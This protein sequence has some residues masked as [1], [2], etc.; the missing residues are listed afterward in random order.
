[1]ILGRQ[2]IYYDA[3][4]G[5]WRDKRL[6]KW[7][8][9]PVTNVMLTT[10]QAI[11]AMFATIRLG[12]N[13]R[14]NGQDPKN[15][16]AAG[17][18]DAYA[19]ILHDE[20]AM[21]DVLADFDFWHIVLGNAFLHTY[22][23]HDLRY[24][25]VQDP[26]EYCPQCMKVGGQSQFVQGC[27]ECGIPTQ[28]VVDPQ[29]GMPV[30]PITYPEQRGQT[31]A[32]SPLEVAF[33]LHY[34][35]WT[36]L[37][38][39]IRLRWRDKYW[40]ENHPDDAV[41][42]LVPTISWQK[43]PMERTMQIFKSLPLQNDLG[44]STSYSMGESSSEAEGISEFDVYIKPCEDFPDG[45]VMR[46][47]GDQTPMILHTES[48]GLP[49]PL[50]YHDAEGNPLWTFTH[51]AYRRVGGRILGTGALD[52]IINKQTDLNQLDSLFQM[53]IMRMANPIWLEPKGAEVEKFT[54][55]PGLVVKWNPLTVQG[56]AKP[57]RI[58][59]EGPHQ[60]LF[61]YREQILKDIEEL[62]GTFDV[63]KGAKPTGVEA[64]SAL[65]LLVERGQ[66]RFANA[67]QARGS[68]YAEWFKFALEI[69]REFGPEERTKA[70][71]GPTKGWMFQTFKKTQL[72]GSV[73]IIVEDGT[74]TPKTALG[75]RAAME[76]ASQLGALNLQ[77]PD[78]QYHALTELGLTEF[79]PT[80]DAQV[81]AALQ[82]QQAFEEWIGDPEARMA[83]MQTQQ[84]PLSWKRWYDPIIHRTEFIKWANSER[85][86][87]ALT[88]EPALEGLLDAYLIE[89]DL[90]IQLKQ[91]GMID[92][93]KEAIMIAPPAGPAPGAPGAPGAGEPAGGKKGQIPG[94][95]PPNQPPGSAR[96]LTNSNQNSA[97]AGNTGQ[98]EPGMQA[99]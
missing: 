98:P 34:P 46:V 64:F 26:V 16:I 47:I 68:A 24:G 48:E 13:A 60:S 67:F 51:A 23:D 9:R 56:N 80:L 27:P 94:Q 2:W 78:Q 4:R 14:P 95:T 58:P 36:D 90:A 35:R 99:A 37:P 65:Q 89:I 84:N 43:A 76:H 8:P 29:S 88:K 73:S 57:E 49:G 66:S 91:A 3:R 77:D 62:T 92:I 86:R 10:E 1:M 72:D 54:G 81:Q 53:I 17:A 93:G 41:R 32:L 28:P 96:A 75:R 25:K 20:H 44:V 69:E 7:I 33:P 40:Y 39:V 83:S 30:P 61:M 85:M 97:P 55:E 52:P 79:A 12:A 15:V 45:Y 5:E 87:E 11:A 6:A 70:V 50:P 38:Y 42:A 31:V 21:N 63:L 82:N 22:L 19:P 59:G 18:A 74:N 71:L